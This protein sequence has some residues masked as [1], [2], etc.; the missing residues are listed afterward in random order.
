MLWCIGAIFTKIGNLVE[1]FKMQYLL[2][3]LA[4]RGEDCHLDGRCS[5]DAPHVH[6]GS[7]VFIG[8]GATFV[9]SD[10]QIYIGSHVMFGPNVSIVT[11]NHRTDVVG[12]YMIDVTEKREQDDRDV[13]IEDDVWVGMGATI[14][15]G[16]TIG[17]GSVI[18]AGALVTKSVPPYSVVTTKRE[19]VVRPRFTEKELREHEQKLRERGLQG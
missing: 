1:R 17:R 11:G 12:T 5:I 18:G 19:T 16:V 4:E 2:H 13:V 10:A 8:S 15:K 6:L 7:H 9:S 3:C 14:L